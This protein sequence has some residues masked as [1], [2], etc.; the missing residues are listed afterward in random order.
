MALIGCV[1]MLIRRTG[2][3]EEQP[4]AAFL[5]GAALWLALLSGLGVIWTAFPL[6]ALPVC[7]SPA[8]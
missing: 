7:A 8:G 2:R 3:D 5:R 1:V 4:D 6:A